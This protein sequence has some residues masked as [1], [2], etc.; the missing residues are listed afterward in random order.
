MRLYHFTCEHGAERIVQEGLLRPNP[1][2]KPSVIW[3][4]NL[5]DAPREWLGLTSIILECDRTQYRFSAEVEEPERYVDW[6]KRVRLSR[7]V[8]DAWELAP[9]ALPMHWWISETPLPVLRD[10]EVMR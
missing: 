5:S 6:A 3:L 9:G 4:T 7:R 10:V 2:L 8:R 1:L